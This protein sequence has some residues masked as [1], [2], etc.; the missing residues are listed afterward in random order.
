MGH[1]TRK[2]KRQQSNSHDL[3]LAKCLICYITLQLIFSFFVN[4]HCKIGK[5]CQNFTVFGETC[6][7]QIFE[8]SIRSFIQ[9]IL[10]INNLHKN[11]GCHIKM[12][13]WRPL[14]LGAL[15]MDYKSHRV[16]HWFWCWCYMYWHFGRWSK[17]Y[18]NIVIWKANNPFGLLVRWKVVL[19]KLQK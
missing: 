14:W 19:V 11:H 7:F 16:G 15:L 13:N 8:F 12:K 6:L 1:Q 3:G 18:I 5:K 9:K 2:S 4:V 10:P 17:S